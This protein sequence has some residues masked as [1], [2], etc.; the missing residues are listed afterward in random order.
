MKFLLENLL[1]YEN[2][3]ND[4]QSDYDDLPLTVILMHGE[5]IAL[6]FLNVFLH[7]P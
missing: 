5:S 2:H 7:L 3:D 1:G 4:S 6:H